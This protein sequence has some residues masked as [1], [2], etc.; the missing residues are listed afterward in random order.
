M[1][2]DVEPHQLTQALRRSGMLPVG[3]VQSIA[4]ESTR[5][6]VLSRIVR[7]TLTYEGALADA[8]PSVI[9]KTSHPDRIAAGWTAG[10][11]EVAFYTKVSAATSGRLIPRCFDAQCDEE[12][13]TWY[14]ILED[15]GGT[16]RTVE[17]W[18]LPPT[19]AVCESIV[20]AHARRQALS[21]DAPHLEQSMQAWR[22][23]DAASA[24]QYLERLA[25]QIA[26]FG[27]RFGDRLPLE[28]RALLARLL[29]AAPRLIERYRDRQNLTV[30]QGDAHVWNCFIPNDGG[31]DLRFFD[32]GQLADRRRCERSR[33]YDRNALVSRP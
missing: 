5:M 9:S 14:L 7:L 31:D 25:V 26:V 32:W 23:R 21:W 30:V 3:S 15:L 28:R 1:P 13:K 22:W 20:D 16:H 11:H 4:V 27:D 29:D 10:R 6:T 33:P 17:D 19:M 2:H 24:G 18:P 12:R 8:P